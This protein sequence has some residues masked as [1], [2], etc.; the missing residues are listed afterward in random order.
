MP[1]RL[2]KFEQFK[3]G[4]SWGIIKK[5]LSK[6]GCP[7]CNIVAD[8]TEKYIGFLLRECASDA[9]VH[10]R[11]LKSMGFCKRHSKQILDLEGSDGLNIATIYETLISNELKRLLRSENILNFD[12]KN[13][14]KIRSVLENKKGKIEKVLETTEECFIC[15]N[16][17]KTRLFY[18]HEIIKISEDEEFRRLFENPEVLFCRE[19]FID[20][21][22]ENREE[23]KL[24]Y[25][26]DSHIKKMKQLQE[27]LKSFIEKHKYESREELTDE[28]AKVVR[29]ILFYFGS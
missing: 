25:F 6:K 26:V 8:S 16:E 21:I 9:E 20:L 4:L 29:K 23:N 10:R 12:S 11:N 19:H 7:V 13:F 14:I 18:I 24:K 22:L 2:T 1:S 28:D 15:K 5:S 17:R 3:R 27:G